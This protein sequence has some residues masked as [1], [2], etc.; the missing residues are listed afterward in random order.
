MADL[1]YVSANEVSVPPA[2]KLLAGKLTYADAYSSIDREAS[3]ILVFA[4]AMNDT[5]VAKLF[6]CHNIAAIADHSDYIQTAKSLFIFI[7][8][9]YL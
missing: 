5:L 4:S 7:L 1:I 6:F 9:I 8:N 2:F 3:N